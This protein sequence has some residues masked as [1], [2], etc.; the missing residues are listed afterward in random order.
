MTKFCSAMVILL[1][2]VPLIAKAETDCAALAPV[3]IGAEDGF[4]PYTGLY[5][6]RLGGVSLDIVRA[7]FHASGCQVKFQVM[8]Y[9]R[10][11]REVEKGRIVGCF[12]TT[13]APENKRRYIIH[14][15]PL[16]SGRISVFGHPDGDRT[17]DKARFRRSSFAVV[18]GYTYT[19]EFDLDRSISKIEVE[20][21]QQTLALVSRGR[22]DYAVVYDKVALFHLRSGD[23]T[24]TPAPVRLATLVETDLFISF[25][26]RDTLRSQ[27]LADVLD[28]GLR[29]IRE[30][31]I[32]SGIEKRWSRWLSGTG[33]ADE[34][35]P[36]WQ[37]SPTAN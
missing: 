17:F 21:D 19:D 35:F 27:R 31:G 3:E 8:P 36:Y 2:F 7:A 22:A 12:N 29:K 6:G 16:V 25:T 24:I 34:L 9:N 20:T 33:G 26:R 14:K 5:Q 4:F 23:P 18:R 11:M 13:N 30:N 15:E 28:E 37:P 10:C 32:Y 1:L